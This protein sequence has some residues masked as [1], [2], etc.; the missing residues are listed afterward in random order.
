[1]L[2]WL[3]LFVSCVIAAAAHGRAF[4]DE[5]AQYDA[6]TYQ[7]AV[8]RGLESFRAKQYD[9][10][11]LQFERAHALHPNARTARA[12]GLTAVEL[13]RYSEGWRELQ[14]AL[15]DAREPLTPS[16]RNETSQMI[17]W[18]E[19][20]LGLAKVQLSPPE[21]ALSLDDRDVGGRGGERVLLAESGPHVLAAHAGGYSDKTWNITLS[22]GR[23]E[24]MELRLEPTPVILPP[25]ALVVSASETPGLDAPAEPETGPRDRARGSSIFERWWF[26]TAVGVVVVGGAVAG[27]AL[28][29]SGDPDLA[30][31]QVRAGR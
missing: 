17:A 21:A 29:S 14:E 9:Q 31:H 2:K 13:K 5:R 10:A 18:L 12:L 24:V 6:A 26:W 22:A 20:E 27:I 11:R 23:W 15:G 30:G 25:N 1:M 8:D 4:A 28:A 19:S 16:Q 7:Q 3:A